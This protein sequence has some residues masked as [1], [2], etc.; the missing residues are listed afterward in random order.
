MGKNDMLKK[1]ELEK[2]RKEAERIKQKEEEK[3][4]KA[5]EEESKIENFID[6]N[7]HE[8]FD[9]LNIYQKC[10][11]DEH[12]KWIRIRK[13]MNPKNAAIV[14]KSLRKIYAITKQNMELLDTALVQGYGDQFPEESEDSL[15][16]G[17]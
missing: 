10:L 15:K 14:A 7:I 17:S 13:S 4:K 2:K 9:T 8:A 1:N 16:F 12:K 3:K 6:E 5:K 11:Q